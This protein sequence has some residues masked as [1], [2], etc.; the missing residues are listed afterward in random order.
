MRKKATG[1]VLLAGLLCIA[2]DAAAQSRLYLGMEMGGSAAQALMM[3]GGDNDWATRCDL[4]INP[5]G[6]DLR[7]A[8]CDA[9]PDLTTWSH[10]MKMK[11]GRGALA[12]I[13]LGY[14]FGSFRA[15]LEYFFRNSLHNDMNVPITVGDDVTLDKINEEIATADGGMEDVVSHNSFINVY[16]DIDVSENA[17]VYLGAGVGASN[18]SIGYMTRWQRSPDPADIGTFVD[19]G[20]KAKLAGTTTVGSARLSD[21]VYG[22]QALAGFDRR[23]SGSTTLGLKVRWVKY[24]RFESANHEWDQLRSHDSTVGRGQRIVYWA[25]TSDLQAFAVS[26]AL[27]YDL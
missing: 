5:A 25:G 22:F 3:S 27:K 1:L 16:Y 20:L 18:T 8:E 13:A 4:L 7:G 9:T 24:A 12:S 21:S 10:S 14:R 23:M 26:L 6:V 2:G 15:E 17:A 19:P 11:G